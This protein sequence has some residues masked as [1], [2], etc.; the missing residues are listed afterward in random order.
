MI[1]KLDVGRLLAEKKYSGELAFEFEA[2]KGLTGIPYAE[3]F[4]PVKASLHYEILQDESV[5]ITGRIVFTMK[6]LCSRCLK[7]TETTIDA[8][9][10][11]YFIPR[12]GKGEDGDY[13]YSGGMIDLNEF[14]RDALVFSMPASL[15]CSENC[16]APEY[17]ED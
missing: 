9:A 6:G 3:I 10:E 2:E 12:G 11:G 8:P 13:D 4:A 1:P 17:K 7:E 16:T 5:E 14:L 15:L